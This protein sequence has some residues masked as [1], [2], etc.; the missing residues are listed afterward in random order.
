MEEIVVVISDKVKNLLPLFPKILY[1]SECQIVLLL[2][3]MYF[4]AY[5]A[6]LFV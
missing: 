4:A 5:K 3:K 2:H 1:D 6:L